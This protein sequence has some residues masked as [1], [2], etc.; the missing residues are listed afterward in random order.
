LEGEVT[1]V[2]SRGLQHFVRR[3]VIGAAAAAVVALLPTTSYA[4]NFGFDC[5]T[6][7]QAVCEQYESQLAMEVDGMSS[8]GTNYV[9]FTFFNNVGLASSIGSIY[10]D[11]RIDPQLNYDS[12][13][14]T[15]SSGVDFGSPITA[16]TGGQLPGGGDIL[17]S[18]NTT[19]RFD[20]SGGAA[21]GINAAGEFVQLVFALNVGQTLDTVLAALASGTLRIGLHLTGILP[22]TEGSAGFIAVP[23]DDPD[24]GNPV[25]EPASLLLLGSGL[26]GVAEAA[27]RRRKA[28]A[29]R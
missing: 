10:F 13:M 9:S 28:Q 22:G 7:N 6:T 11:D 4:A 23:G 1:N 14:S 2:M 20:R 29:T 18:F 17:P 16:Q 21:N 27:R 3:A 12:T 19:A 15:T 25:P 26:A 5:I 24:P 8:G